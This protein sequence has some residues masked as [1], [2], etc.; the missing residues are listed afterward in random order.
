[1]LQTSTPARRELTARC[2]CVFGSGWRT[3][4]L[5]VAVALVLGAWLLL[6]T[7]APSKPSIVVPVASDERLAAVVGVTAGDRVV[8]EADHDE[9]A[10]DKQAD[11]DAEEPEDTVED[12]DT[13]ALADGLLMT[14][15]WHSSQEF[16]YTV[17]V[18]AIFRGESL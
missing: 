15:N 13:A 9:Q 18:M 7:T 14:H 3:N 1:M 2:V 4:W 8:E 6:F 11:E 16:K 17:A 12:H 10:E 5:F